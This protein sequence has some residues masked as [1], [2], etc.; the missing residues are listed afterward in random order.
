MFESVAGQDEKVGRFP[1][2]DVGNA[3]TC[4]EA[5]G[6]HPISS[7]ANLC[8]GH[9]DLPIARMHKLHAAIMRLEVAQGMSYLENSFNIDPTP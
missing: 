9:A 6:A 5:D 3:P 7:G 1:S 4:F 2:A 8:R